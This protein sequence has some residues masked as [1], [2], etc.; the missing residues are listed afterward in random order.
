[1]ADRIDIRHLD[2]CSRR[3]ASGSGGG[4]LYTKQIGFCFLGGPMSNAVRSVRRLSVALSRGF[5]QN[6][7]SPCVG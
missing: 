4:R 7:D 6:E 1:M 3:R 5:G 2:Y